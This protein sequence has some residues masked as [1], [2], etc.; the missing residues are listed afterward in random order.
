MFEFSDDEEKDNKI[1]V[2]GYPNFYRVMDIRNLFEKYG[3]IEEITIKK[4][5]AFI[6]FNHFCEAENAIKRMNGR[7]LWNQPLRVQ[8]STSTFVDENDNYVDVNGMR[9]KGTN[10]ECFLCGQTGHWVKDCPKHQNNKF[11]NGVRPLEMY[12]ASGV[13]IIHNRME[14]DELHCYI[15]PGKHEQ[16]GC[17]LYKRD[18]YGEK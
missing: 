18:A 3:R 14:A 6:V 11:S 4:N 7:M 10:N 9:V 1:F 17:F 12:G 8:L 16:I 15:A 13:D 2:T 5:Y